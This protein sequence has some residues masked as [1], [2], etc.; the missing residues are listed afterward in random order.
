[1][2]QEFY[3]NFK[4]GTMYMLVHATFMIKRKRLTEYE[5]KSDFIFTPMGLK[6]GYRVN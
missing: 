6:M 2:V 3:Y 4:V 5:K 1:M